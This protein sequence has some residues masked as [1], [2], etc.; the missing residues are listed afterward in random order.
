MDVGQNAQV[1]LNASRLRAITLSRSITSVC[2]GKTTLFLSYF[3][4]KKSHLSHLSFFY[5]KH[6]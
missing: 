5:Y 3:H 6:S 1:N 2:A 4:L